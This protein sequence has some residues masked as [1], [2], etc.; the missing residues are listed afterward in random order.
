MTRM[1][2]GCEHGS[3]YYEQLMVVVDMIQGGEI[4]DLDVISS[5]KLWMI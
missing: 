3:K 1:T 4:K 2:L 5:S